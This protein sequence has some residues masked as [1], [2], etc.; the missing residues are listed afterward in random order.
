MARPSEEDLLDEINANLPPGVDWKEGAV[1]YLRELVVNGGETAEWYHLVKPFVGGPDFDSFWVDLFHFW[2][3][4]HKVDLPMRSR[5]LDVGCGP[6]WTVHWLAKLGHHVIGLDISTELLAIAERRMQSDPFGP[7]KGEPFSYELAAH[8]IEAAPLNLAEPV[9]LALFESTLHHFYDPVAVLRNVAADLAPDGVLAVIEAA[10]PPTDSEWHRANVDLMERYHTIERPYTRRQILDMLQLAGYEYCQFFR[11]L[12]GLHAQDADSINGLVNEVGRADNINIFLASPRRQGLG[13]IVADPEPLPRW[14]TGFHYLDGFFAAESR[15]DGSRFRWAGP[16][17]AVRFTDAGTYGLHVSTVSLAPSTTQRVFCLVDGE[18]TAAETLSWSSPGA[19]LA[20]T[21]GDDA[22]VELQSDRAFS[23]GWDGAGDRRVLSF[24][25]DESAG[26]GQ[27]AG[28][29]ESAGLR[30]S[31]AI[32]A[33]RSLGRSL[34]SRLR[35][36]DT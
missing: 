7:F 2:D 4:V 25:V 11:P 12:H 29:A 1:T 8:D 17:A 32:T 20:V 26:L 5:V 13:R 16:Q 3:V 33:A 23:P 35:H 27:S 18:I 22:V 21:V 30:G 14:R 6:G 34:R 31:S 24:M 28:L 36:G 19:Q 9:R 10:A 15:P